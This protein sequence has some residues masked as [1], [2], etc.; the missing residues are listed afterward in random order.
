MLGKIF[1]R[2][3]RH[4][5][6][7]GERYFR[8]ER[9][10]DARHAFQEAL[11]KADGNA[12][13]VRSS[14]Q[15]KLAET[16][17]QLGLLNL[18]EA[19]H[20]L[21]MGNSLKAE[22]HLDLVLE[23]TTDTGLRDKALRLRASLSSNEEECPPPGP[24]VK[25]CGGC[26]QPADPEPGD[27]P[28]S[29]DHL[30]DHERFE[31]LIQTLPEEL[32]LRYEALG[33]TFAKGYLLIHDGKDQEGETVLANLPDAGDNDIVLYELALLNF[34][35]GSP[36]VCEQMLRRAIETNS[37]NPL[38]YLG[39][40]QLLTDTGRLTESIPVLQFMIDN[41]LL[42]E[43]AVIFLGD[44]NL[45][46]GKIDIAMDTYARA[47]DLPAAAKAAAERLV[48]LLRENNRNEEAAFLF[49][50]YLKGCC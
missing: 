46:L 15:L 25:Y 28:S 16:G 50:K 26:S 7:K 36:D 39:L 18:A 6:E 20:A 24:A 9:Y 19:E 37:A 10:A 45:N 49:K 1:G 13:D 3:Y 48:P 21:G 38:C 5:L 27:M 32:A 40:V 14:I 2:D 43:Q 34:R 47:L 44:V 35:K 11:L 42:T 22:E 4:Y 41:Q 12:E 33:D 23:L 8:D 30:S 17:N 31:L 29:L